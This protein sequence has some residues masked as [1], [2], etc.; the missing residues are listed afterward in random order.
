MLSNGKG[1]IFDVIRS[2]CRIQRNLSRVGN[3]ALDGGS[4][5]CQ[6]RSQKR[7]AAS[8][9]P[10]LKISVTGAYRA[11]SRFQFVP[12]HG[13]AHGAAGF[14]PFGAGVPEDPVESLRFGL[15]LHG[16]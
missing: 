13:D 7:A 4:R 11:L 9:L 12:I 16:L 10:S 5:S 3:S 14:A 1:K 2:N 8:A 15:A 6:R